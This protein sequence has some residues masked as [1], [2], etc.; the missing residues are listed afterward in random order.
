MTGKLDAYMDKN[1]PAYF[2][3]SEAWRLGEPTSHFQ[4]TMDGLKAVLAPAEVA[5]VYV[6][7]TWSAELGEIAA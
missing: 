5:E 1:R 3:D 6:P 7:E 4:V 2:A